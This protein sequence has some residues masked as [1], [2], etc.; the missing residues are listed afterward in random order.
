MQIA[1]EE[2]FFPLGLGN[3]WGKLRIGLRCCAYSIAGMQDAMQLTNVNYNDFRIGAA[4]CNGRQG[5]FTPGATDTFGIYGGQATGYPTVLSTAA[6]PWSVSVAGGYTF[7]QRQ[8]ANTQHTVRSNSTGSIT[9]RS[10]IS[11]NVY[12]SPLYFDFDRVT[13]SGSIVYSLFARTTAQIA[14]VPNT[15]FAEFFT[16]MNI[17]TAPTNTTNVANTVQTTAY[18]GTAN[19]FDTLS[20]FCNSTANFILEISHVAVARQL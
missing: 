3:N 17:T 18:L 7:F 10:Y 16:G 1:G 9:V 2:V 8:G 4:L 6:I 14:T 20:I 15:S 11:T 5:F 13:T 12:W 19:Y